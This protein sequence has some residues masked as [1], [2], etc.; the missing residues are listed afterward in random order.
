MVTAI[1]HWNTL[2]MDRM[3]DAFRAG[4]EAVPAHLLDRLSPLGWE[5]VNLTG[6]CLW[7]EKPLLDVNGFRPIPFTL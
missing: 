1:I 3:V 4:G 2:Y 6:D 5:H 7:E